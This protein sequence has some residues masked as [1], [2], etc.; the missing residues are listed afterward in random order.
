MAINHLLNGM[1]LQVG[2]DCQG[3]DPLNLP[4]ALFVKRFSVGAEERHGHMHTWASMEG[5]RKG[6]EIKALRKGLLKD[7][8]GEWKIP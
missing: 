4:L 7:D 8:G 1:I 3:D 5:S 6:Q 2:S